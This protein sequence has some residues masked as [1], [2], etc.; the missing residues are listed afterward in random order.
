MDSLKQFLAM[1]GYAAFVW[2]ALGIAAAVMVGLLVQS[3]QSL[4]ARE[5]ELEKLGGGEELRRNAKP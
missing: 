1:G 5:E 2:P 3:L 4:R